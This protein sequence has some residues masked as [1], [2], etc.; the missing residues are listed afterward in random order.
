MHNH[1]K[2]IKYLEKLY[3]TKLDDYLLVPR[4]MVERIIE[5]LK[6]EDQHNRT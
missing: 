3:N 6:S 2:I 1:K 5:I 4:E